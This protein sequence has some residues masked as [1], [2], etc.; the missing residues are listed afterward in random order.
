MTT[1]NV[2]LVLAS[3]WSTATLASSQQIPPAP[4]VVSPAAQQ[5]TTESG[6]R[7]AHI[8]IVVADIDKTRVR[9]LNSEITAI[10]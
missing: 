9:H 1:K 3:L 7:L 4:A 5:A 8:A 10:H 6:P 2:I